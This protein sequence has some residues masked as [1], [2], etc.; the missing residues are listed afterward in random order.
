[1]ATKNYIFLNNQHGMVTDGDSYVRTVELGAKRAYLRGFTCI[2]S[3]TDTHDLS[4]AP[5]LATYTF[6]TQASVGS[7]WGDYRFLHREV[8]T[9]SEW[10]SSEPFMCQYVPLTDFIIFDM[11][12]GSYALHYSVNG[13]SS[14]QHQQIKWVLEQDDVVEA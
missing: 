9:L 4:A 10:V 8:V 13:N 6:Y 11:E 12:A 2:S 7:T 14:R 5:P 3:C 1:M